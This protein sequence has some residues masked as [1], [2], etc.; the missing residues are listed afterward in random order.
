MGLTFTTK[1]TVIRNFVANQRP[2]FT[3]V[4]TVCAVPTF[5]T[6]QKPAFVK[7]IVKDL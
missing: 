2:M 1:G 7:S 5:T 4:C 3:I 6:N